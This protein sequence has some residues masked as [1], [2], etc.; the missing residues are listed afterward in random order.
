MAEST[1][2]INARLSPALKERGDSVLKRN[3]VSTTQAVRALW[4]VMARTHEV[5]GFILDECG[6]VQA[7]EKARKREVARDLLGIVRHSS[8]ISDTDLDDARF[9]GLMEKYEALS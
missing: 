9:K 5:P 2:T 7:D 1:A 4:G 6:K 8:S 3:G